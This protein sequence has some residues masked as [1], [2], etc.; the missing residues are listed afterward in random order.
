M[1]SQKPSLSIFMRGVCICV[2]VSMGECA[3]THELWSSC[4]EVKGHCVKVSSLLLPCGFQG[5]NSG[6]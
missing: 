3:S 2:C 6:H 5:L 4:V 1:N